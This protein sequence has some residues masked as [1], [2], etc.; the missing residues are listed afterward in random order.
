MGVG[1]GNS[2]GPAYHEGV[3]LLGILESPIELVV[4][5]PGVFF[6]LQ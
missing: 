5:L 6:G 3:P 2:M 4:S 1:L